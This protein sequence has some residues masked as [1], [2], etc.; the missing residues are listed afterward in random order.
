MINWQFY[1]KSA[2]IP[3]HLRRVVHVFEAHEDVIGSPLHSLRSDDVLQVVAEDLASL[4]YRVEIG[5]SSAGRIHVPVLFGRNGGTE[6][7]FA[8][9]AWNR[10]TRSVLEV[11]AG[12]AVANYQFLKDLFEACMMHDVTHLAIAM[13]NI[14]GGGGFESRDFEKVSTF[15]DTLYASGRLKLPLD[16]ILIV[17]Y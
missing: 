15:F 9:D 4:G 7:A 1:P 14:Y 11:E 12:R 3:D 16:G 2:E 13:R 10:Q 8:A 6:Q 17:G 5:K